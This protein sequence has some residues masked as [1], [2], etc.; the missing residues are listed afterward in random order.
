MKKNYTLIYP[1]LDTIMEK[2]LNFTDDPTNCRRARTILA[3]FFYLAQYRPV[4]SDHYCHTELSIIYLHV[5]KMRDSCPLFT[6][7]F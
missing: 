3:I 6:S 2:L 7:T 4:K 1:S 5:L